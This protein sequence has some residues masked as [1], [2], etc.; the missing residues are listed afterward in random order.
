MPT[1]SRT[2]RQQRRRWAAVNVDARTPSGAIDL[3]VGAGA[4]DQIPDLVAE[5]RLLLLL[6]AERVDERER[7]V[8][9]VAERPDGLPSTL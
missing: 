4:E 7:L 3:A 2:S 8:V 1:H 9:L 6:V 5:D